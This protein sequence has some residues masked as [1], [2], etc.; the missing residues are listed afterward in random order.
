MI[1]RSITELFE[2]RKAHL[3]HRVK[4]DYIR[5]GIATIPCQISDYSDVIHSYSVQGC[6]SLNPEFVEY[7]RSTTELMPPEC[8]LIL[9][10]IWDCMSE[11]EK[12]IIEKTIQDDFAYDLGVVEK[13]ES[14]HTRTFGLMFWD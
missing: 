5:N 11:E 6:E 9:N 2:S 1:G 4:Q 13:E 10:I 12:E 7:V 3:D 8:P 14:R